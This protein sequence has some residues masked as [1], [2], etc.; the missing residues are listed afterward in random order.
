M[1]MLLILTIAGLALLTIGSPGRLM[2][3]GH[4]LFDAVTHT[5][6][7]VQATTAK[8]DAMA[9]NGAINT[10]VTEPVPD[11]S[12]LPKQADIPASS[13]LHGPVITPETKSTT[14]ASAIDPTPPQ[15]DQNPHSFEQIQSLDIDTTKILDQIESNN[16]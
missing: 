4:G 7:A 8:Q 12:K 5:G 13:V 3:V 11:F 16:Q 2:Q 6:E 9:N 15:E 10:P 14:L 1:R